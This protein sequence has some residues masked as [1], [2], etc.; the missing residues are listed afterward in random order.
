MWCFIFL[1][2][3]EG[4]CSCPVLTWLLWIFGLYYFVVFELLRR[5]Q[6]LGEFNLMWRRGAANPSFLLV[7][8]SGTEGYGLLL[9]NPRNP[10]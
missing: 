3:L 9:M 2:F 1:L 8:G 6:Q 7:R 5:F 4:V 10:L